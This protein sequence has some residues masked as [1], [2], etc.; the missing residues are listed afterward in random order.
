MLEMKTKLPF[1]LLIDQEKIHK[2]VSEMAE[3]ITREYC[4]KTPVF[5]GVLKG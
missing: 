4:D 3:E 1:E 5:V 2:R